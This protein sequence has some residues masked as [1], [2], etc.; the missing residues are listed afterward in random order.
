MRSLVSVEV[1]ITW[2]CHY[3]A[4]SLRSD[5]VF[6]TRLYRLLGTCDNV[7]IL[8]LPKGTHKRDVKFSRGLAQLREVGKQI[9]DFKDQFSVHIGSST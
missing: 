5:L 8:R 9:L 3:V 2:R 4:M 7:S 6:D 1:V